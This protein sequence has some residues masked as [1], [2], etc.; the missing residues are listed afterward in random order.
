MISNTHPLLKIL[1]M[2]A[3]TPVSTPVSASVNVTAE[4]KEKKPRK[5]TLPAKYSKFIQ[6][7][8]WLVQKLKDEDGDF[9]IDSADDFIEA[10]HLF[11]SVDAQQEFVQEFFDDSKDIAKTIRKMILDKTRAEAKATKAAEKAAAKAA[12][13][14]KA[15]KE[16]VV[17]EPK[18]PKAEKEAKAPKAEKEA[19]APKAEKEAKAPKAPKAPKAG[20]GKTDKEVVVTEEVEQPVLQPVATEKAKKGKGKKPVVD[21][22]FVSEV[23]SLANA[24]AEPLN[25]KPKRKYN[26]KDKPSQPLADADAP[27]LAVSVFEFQGKQFLI[28]DNLRVFDFHSHALLGNFVN[29]LIVYL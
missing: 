11:D 7:G 6:F 17:K 26:K 9:N 25:D 3:S 2:S 22:Q 23:V 10:I 27:E 1:K 4:I 5:P 13:P 12:A 29:D 21:D 18:A 20:G 24:Q 19:K 14:P 16:K 28:D 8:F 15:P